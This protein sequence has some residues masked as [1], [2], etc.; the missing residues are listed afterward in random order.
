[1]K[2]KIYEKYLGSNELTF[3]VHY[4]DRVLPVSPR[5]VFCLFVCLFLPVNVMQW[6]ICLILAKLLETVSLKES[7]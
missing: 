4:G 2:K 3:K 6:Y 7:C 5:S 1:M